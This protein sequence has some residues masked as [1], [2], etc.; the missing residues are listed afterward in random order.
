MRMTR[1]TT[2]LRP[3][4]G[5]NQGRKAL[6]VKAVTVKLTPEQIAHVQKRGAKHKPVGMSA[7]L[8]ALIDADMTK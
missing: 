4:P 1:N 7:Y 5:N 3:G 2:G 8:R 6:G